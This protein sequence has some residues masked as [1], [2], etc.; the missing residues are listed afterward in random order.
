MR[1]SIFR[2]I[3]YIM[4]CATAA[5]TW[6]CVSDSPQ[7]L[8]PRITRLIASDITRTGAIITATTTSSGSGSLSEIRIHYGVSADMDTTTEYA[9]AESSTATF[10]LEGLTPGKTYRCMGEGRSSES[11]AHILSDTITFTTQPNERPKLGRT[12][13]LSSGPVGVIARL[14]ILD[15]GGGAVI[16]A[17][18]KVKDRVSESM[19]T[20]QLICDLSNLPGIFTLYINGLEQEHEYEITPY[21]TNDSGESLGDMMTFS[22]GRGVYLQEAGL[23]RTLLE[24]GK[25]ESEEL[26]IVGEMNGDDF[27][28]LRAML[29]APEDIGV[30]APSISRVNIADASI[31]GSG[32]TYDGSRYTEDDVITTGLFADCT[33]LQ[34]ISLPSSAISIRRDAFSRCGRLETLQIPVSVE[35]LTPTSDC[36]VLRSIAVSP[37]NNFFRSHDGVL[38]DKSMTQLIWF[39]V[40][41]EGDFTFPPS[42]TSLG[43]NALRGS[44]LFFITLPDDLLEFGRGAL[45]DMMMEKITIPGG[46]KSLPEALLQ[47][48]SKLKEVHIGHGTEMIGKYAFYGCPLENIYLDSEIPPVVDECSFSPEDSGLF[49]RCVLH[50]PSQSRDIYR[51][52]KIWKKFEIIVIQ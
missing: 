33:G 51:N 27:R 52:H 41:K 9:A 43:E 34:S 20:R 47:G 6:G 46:V 49:S 17:G 19:T 18:F 36:P 30:R 21:A 11:T 12:E 39:P 25:I 50:V 22:A 23:L 15:D 14:E 40:G 5:M 31:R 16:S 48:C 7:H 38:F 44:S 32:G 3:V 45:S 28:F 29:G 35:N 24:N 4:A 1:H 42:V 13:F 26:M 2:H 8:Q 10:V 37:A